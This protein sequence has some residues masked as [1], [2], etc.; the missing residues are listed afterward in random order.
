MTMVRCGVRISMSCSLF[1]YP[2]FGARN[3]SRF[4]RLSS[5]VLGPVSII[6]SNIAPI[7]PPFDVGNQRETTVV[8]RTHSRH[9]II[10]YRLSLA[11]FVYDG[12]SPRAT[13]RGQPHLCHCFRISLTHSHRS[14]W[15]IYLRSYGDYVLLMRCR[16]TQRGTTSIVFLSLDR[17]KHQNLLVWR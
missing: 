17:H 3:N 8:S 11:S 5:C 16:R 12:L 13:T 1:S 10:D 9:P 4:P 2:I 7:S 6:G 14:S 15:H